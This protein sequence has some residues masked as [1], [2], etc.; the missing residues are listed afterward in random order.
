MAQ[1]FLH[2]LQ[3]GVRL[4]GLGV[5]HPIGVQAGGGQA[6][7]EQVGVFHHPQHRA[8]LAGQDA[9]D[10]QRR[11]GAVL[12]VRA[13]AGHLVQDAERQAAPGR[14]ASIG[15]PRG[16]VTRRWCGPGTLDAGDAGPQGF[17]QGSGGQGG[18]WL[19]HLFSLTRRSAGGGEQEHI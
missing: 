5:D 2:G 19:V 11:G 16:M 15:G 9:G 1:A 10:E 8:A 4:A 18:G 7:G 12:G 13:G 6:G 17:D 3:N 14:A